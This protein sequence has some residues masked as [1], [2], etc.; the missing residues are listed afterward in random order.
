ME[1]I[2]ILHIVPN[3]QQGGIE[4][5]LM[6]IYRNIDRNK[7]QFDFL[8]HYQKK[9]T[10]DDEIERLGGKIYRCSF[11]EDNN[12]LKYYKDLNRFFKE[13]TEYKIVHAHMASLAYIYLGLAKK[14]GINIRI[15][16]SHGTSHLKNLKGYAKYFLFKLADINANIRWS[17][18]T[19]AG[20]YLFR[21]KKF[22]VIPNAIDMER[23]KYNEEIR[24]DK[25]K[26][27]GLEDK[28]VIG[29]IGRFNLQKNHEFIID[30]FYELQK[31]NKNAVLMLIGTGE[32]EEKI[33]QK[34]SNL[35]IE[36]KVLFMGN[37]NN[38]EEMYQVM[39]IF[40]MPSLFEGLPVTGV[41]AQVSGLYCLFADTITREVQISNNCKFIPLQESKQIWKK[42]IISNNSNNREQ[43]YENIKESIFNI[44]KLSKELEKKYLDLY[45]GEMNK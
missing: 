10:F 31:E 38:V 15:I 16:H 5:F 27:M 33:K 12:F 19:E 18:S 3:M 29:N 42:E 17:C 40:I 45:Y 23:F 14:Y 26:E 13:H 35:K 41:E 30:V 44:K 11:R 39:D 37:I 7:I 1:P 22:E 25:R 32:L 34:V 24:N 43:S 2:R 6:N 28:F 36:D 8:V 4:N 9:F 21:K 20:K